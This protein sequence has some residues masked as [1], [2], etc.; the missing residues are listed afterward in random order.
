MKCVEPDDPD[1]DPLPVAAFTWRAGTP[2]LPPVPPA[3]RPRARAVEPPWASQFGPFPS[4]AGR[5]RATVAK[6]AG[7]ALGVVAVIC[8]VVWLVWPIAE[9]DEPPAAAT[10]SAV[11]QP[12]RDADAEARLL[13][14]LPLGY[15][16][17]RCTPADL[18]SAAVAKFECGD[19][20]DQGGPASA[21][22]AVMSDKAALEVAFDAVVGGADK[23]NCPGNIQS[24]GPWRR[25]A[26][27]QK[28]AGTVFC[29]YR[30]SLPI[31]A[32]TTDE[33]LLLSSISAD[34]S[35]PGLDQL[36]AWWSTHS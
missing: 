36:Y 13:R 2:N 35:G 18:S 29:G 17:G 8:L 28:T 1:T 31:V 7:A 16:K 15:P 33:S 26:T 6:I 27:P 9:D 20:V 25:N 5:D 22:Y 11:P 19:N 10:T 21:T 23:V 14:L 24:P 34:G 4:G 12:T 32:W 3:Q 30:K